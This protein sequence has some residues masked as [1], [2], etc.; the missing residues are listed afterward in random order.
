MTRL[1][2]GVAATV[3]GA[4]AF[5]AGASTALIG[6]AMHFGVALA[7]SLVFALMVSQFDAIRRALGK[8]GGPI[9]IASIYGPFIWMVMS[10][11]VIPQ[12]TGRPP[13]IT[14]RWWVQLIGHI[15]F[16]ALP[17]VTIIGLPFRPAPASATAVR[18]VS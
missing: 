15:P 8:P 5:D 16:V 2:Q 6:L 3:I 7:W 18:R 12:L 1:W 9:A 17:I 11:G 13:V 14:S 4:K 10:L